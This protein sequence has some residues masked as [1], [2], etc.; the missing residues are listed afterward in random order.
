MSE[1]GI[2]KGGM[3]NGMCVGFLSLARVDDTFLMLRN[4][5]GDARTVGKKHD[6]IVMQPDGGS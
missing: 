6:E 2:Q 4:W 1:N 5:G 3:V